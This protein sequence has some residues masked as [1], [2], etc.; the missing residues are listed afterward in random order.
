MKKEPCA[1]KNNDRDGDAKDRAH[2]PDQRLKFCERTGTWGSQRR[3]L[4]F[5]EVGSS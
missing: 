2:H 3:H 5:T 4:N 1:G